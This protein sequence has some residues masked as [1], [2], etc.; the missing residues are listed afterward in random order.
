MFFLSAQADAE[1]RPF[2]MF[3]F[4]SVTECHHGSRC[5]VVHFECSPSGEQELLPCDK[6]F[7][8]G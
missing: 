3:P 6:V 4:V 7:A 2:Q 5:L 8:L 1:L